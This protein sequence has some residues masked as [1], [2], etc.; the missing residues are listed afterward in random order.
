MAQGHRADSG[1]LLARRRQNKKS[2]LVAVE[3]HS[4]APCDMKSRLHQLLGIELFEA[5]AVHGRIGYKANVVV[6][7]H[8]MIERDIPIV[9][10]ALDGKGMVR[11][12]LFGLLGKHR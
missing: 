1:L 5:D 3:I 4:A 9:L 6:L 2:V 12:R 11:I 7:G 10:D 8:G